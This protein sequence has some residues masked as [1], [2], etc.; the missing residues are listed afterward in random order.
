M[1]VLDCWIKIQQSWQWYVIGYFGFG[2][3]IYDVLFI[4]N[5]Y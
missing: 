3:D 1:Q 5:D 4:V 2:D